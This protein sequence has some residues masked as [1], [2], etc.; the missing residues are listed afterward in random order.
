MGKICV[1]DIRKKQGT[2]NTFTKLKLSL[3]K[4]LEEQLSESSDNRY[5]VS[6]QHSQAL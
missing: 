3:K 5:L 2:R 6:C 1:A 4:K